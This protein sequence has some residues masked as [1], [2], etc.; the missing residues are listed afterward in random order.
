MYQDDTYPSPTGHEATVLPSGAKVRWLGTRW[1]HAYPI[2]KD[3]I[4]SAS[5]CGREELVLG[6]RVSVDSQDPRCPQCQW[7]WGERQM[8]RPMTYSEAWN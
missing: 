5:L 6:I 7:L 3:D 8:N 1:A 2:V 4:G